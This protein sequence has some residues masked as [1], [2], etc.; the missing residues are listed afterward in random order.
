[1]EAARAAH[2]HGAAVL[3]GHCDDGLAVPYQPFAEAM[4]KAVRQ[5]PA[6]DLAPL[7]GGRGGELVRLVPDLAELSSTVPVPLSSDPETD[8]YRMFEATGHALSALARRAPVVLV[9][10]DLHWATKPTLLLLRHVTTRVEP[11][12][13]LIVGTYRDTE[14]G[15]SHP[16]TDVLGERMADVTRIRL[17]GL[18]EDDVRGFVEALNGG[19]DTTSA[20]RA[21]SLYDVSAGNALFMREMARHLDESGSGDAAS[22]D[23]GAGDVPE[24]IREVVRRRLSRLSATT[25]RLLSVASVV[26]TQY[27]LDVVQVAVGFDEDSVLSGLE[28]AIH[29]GLVADV[30]G[31]TLR[32]R[33][34]HALV[35][36][37]LYDE[38]SAGRRAQL[39][40]RVGEAIELA[41]VGS[42]DDL[43]ELARHFAAAAAIGGAPKAVAYST[44][45]GEQALTQLAHDDAARHFRRGLD[46]LELIPVEPGDE[47]L[48]RRL[49]CDLLLSLGEAQKRCG[50][51]SHRQ[52]LLDAAALAA[53]LGD[54]ERLA[55][56][57]LA[58]TRG[59]WS[60]TLRVD[61]DRVAT[62]EAA[63]AALDPGDSPL[64]A[65]LLARLAVELVFSG[66]AAA[67]R[68]LSDDALA[69]A[70][71]LGDLPTLAQVLAP[72][73]NTIRGDPATLPERLADTAELVAVAGQ[74]PDLSLRCEAWGWRAVATMEAA[75]VEEAAACLE[76]HRRLA[77]QLRQPT[78]LWYST[79]LDAARALLGGRFDDAERLAVE[80]N[81]L[82]HL[83]GQPDADMFLS[84]QRMEIAYERG[85]LGR[86]ERPLRIAVARDPASRSFLR[87]WQ[88]LCACERGDDEAARAFFDDLASKDFAD[89]PFEPTW[90]GIVA[91]S[92]AVCAQLGDTARAG[93]LIELLA[94]FADQLVT[95]TSLAYCGGVSH[96]LGMLAATLGDGGAADGWFAAAAALHR[97]IDAPGWLARTQLEWGRS[98]VARGGRTDEAADLLRAAHDT[99]ARLGMASV[100]RR[101]VTL[102]S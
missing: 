96:Y 43:P 85:L 94:P 33:F 86:W 3:V 52:T 49:R 4:A 93:R 5:L 62:F 44:R 2:S 8:R 71:R 47:D 87:A 72:R 42:P 17:T 15:E 35:R 73:Y 24:S 89:I 99:A 53:D 19:D 38:L 77:I 59:F 39:H 57:A 97:R 60:A 78:M 66:D 65:R 92:A 20:R 6:E 14:V 11:M 84:V 75:D 67:V 31:P 50:D 68:R 83:A 55:A 10:D 61:A 54:A 21:R 58:N 90:L 64:R 32:Q 22:G 79:Y 29:A 9:L 23:A 70:R 30:G 51:P 88:A 41:S 26:G 81:R 76:A 80:A 1:M 82:G 28:E 48:A 7:L 101:A 13:L 102:L 63:L 56:A 18:G 12:P 36:D 34:T 25:N 16:V 46:L 95:L 91:T 74:L 37:V 98:L 100:E 40:R 27:E 45:A 69:M